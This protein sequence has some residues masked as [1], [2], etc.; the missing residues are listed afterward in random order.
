MRHFAGLV[1]SGEI[2]V[3]CN[4]LH[5]R[6]PCLLPSDIHALIEVLHESRSGKKSPK[7]SPKGRRPGQ[8]I[9]VHQS[10]DLWLQPL[11]TSAPDQQDQQMVG[12]RAEG[13]LYLVIPWIEVSLPSPTTQQRG[14]R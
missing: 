13:I 2:V 7:K 9:T 3:L 6:L 8:Y 10:R 5:L 4:E 12:L 14:R 11:S 1:H